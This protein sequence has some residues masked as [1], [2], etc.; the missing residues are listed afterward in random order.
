MLQCCLPGVLQ[1]D[2]LRRVTQPGISGYQLTDVFFLLIV[3]SRAE[4]SPEEEKAAGRKMQTGR[5]YWK[6]GPHL[7]QRDFAQLGNNVRSDVTDTLG[8]MSFLGRI[9]GKQLY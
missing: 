5:K 2:S 6:C 9:Y 7:E 3:M 1:P 8:G 4:R